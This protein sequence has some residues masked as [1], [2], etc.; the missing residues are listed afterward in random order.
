[1]PEDYIPYK[2]NRA[3]S[4]ILGRT[5]EQSG[6]ELQAG[7]RAELD[8]TPVTMALSSM[9]GRVVAQTMSYI[10]HHQGARHFSASRIKLLHAVMLQELSSAIQHPI[11][12]TI[13]TGFSPLCLMLAESLPQGKIIEID[14]PDVIRKRRTRLRRANDITIPENIV[15]YDSDLKSIPLT[16]ILGDD[17]PHIMDFTSAYYPQDEMIRLAAYLHSI[18]QPG[19]VLVTYTPYA[20]GVDAVRSATRFFKNQIGD[21]PGMVS[22]TAEAVAVYQKAGFETVEVKLP[23]VLAEEID[24]PRPMLDIEIL[25]IARKA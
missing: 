13:A 24:L 22:N 16:D 17:R 7:L 19:G 3:D 23:S 14:L 8:P 12:L 20:P 4:F 6:S 11:T 2:P 10:V 9:R 25:V 5:Q 1:M 18:L 15:T 21:L